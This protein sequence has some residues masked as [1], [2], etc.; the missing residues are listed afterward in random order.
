MAS[1]FVVLS[2]GFDYVTKT[3]LSKYEK[4]FFFIFLNLNL[5]ITT[6]NYQHLQY[7]FLRIIGYK[8]ILLKFSLIK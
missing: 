8:N 3:I 7:L 6:N 5:N 2:L 1:Y 4:L